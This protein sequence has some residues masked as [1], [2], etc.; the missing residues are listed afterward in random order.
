MPNHPPSVEKVRE[1]YIQALGIV[2]KTELLVAEYVKLRGSIP[3]HSAWVGSGFYH[4]IATTQA[5][6]VLRYSGGVFIDKHA[7]GQMVQLRSQLES[8]RRFLENIA[9]GR[10]AT[11]YFDWEETKQE[12]DGEG[13]SYSIRGIIRNETSREGTSD[14][15]GGGVGRKREN[16]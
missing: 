9:N 10:S 7:D 14:G 12:H 6:T 11:Y 5:G 1:A 3:L 2:P 4:S 13:W 15:A 8:V 16:S